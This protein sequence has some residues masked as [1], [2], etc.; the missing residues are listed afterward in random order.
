MNGTIT[1]FWV[2]GYDCYNRL[3]CN[4]NFDGSERE[5]AY[6]TFREWVDGGRYYYVQMGAWT[7]EGSIVLNEY[8]K[9]GVT[10][11]PVSDGA[12]QFMQ[13]FVDAGIDH[14]FITTK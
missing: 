5:R 6:E 13:A 9:P 2:K 10:P 14:G 7:S 1:N 4:P 11:K 3:S 12:I 8:R